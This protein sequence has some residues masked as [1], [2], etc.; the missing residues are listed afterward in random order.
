[1]SG[2]LDAGRSGPELRPELRPDLVVV[3]PW[4]PTPQSPYSGTFV[5]ESVRALMPHTRSVT[6]VHVENQP[7]GQ[8]RRARWEDTP[9]GRLRWIPVP[10]AANTSRGQMMLRQRRALR[11][12]AQRVLS[13]AEVVHCHVGAP[14]AAALTPLLPESARLVVTEHATYL[15][16]VF[17][18]PLARPL[19]RAALRR[20]Q[21]FTA[22]SPSTA[23]LIES[24]FPDT[25]SVQTVP[26]PVELARL[27]VRTTIRPGLPRWLFVGNLIPHKGV[28]RLLRSFAGYLSTGRGDPE[29]TLS[30]AGDG[31][32][33][34][35]L[36]QLAEQLGVA[37][38]V[39]FLGPVAPERVGEVYAGHDLL[40][41]LS[42]VETFGLTCVEAAAAGLAVVVTR[43]GA[44]TDTL[45][46]HRELGLARFVPVN[47][48]HDTGPVV[49]AVLS[50]VDEL[51]DA[52]RVSS[53]LAL[54][55][56]HL[57][58]CYGMRS[59][60]LRLAAAVTGTAAGPL[61]P[62]SGLRGVAV[63]VT[64]EQLLAGQA[65]LADVAD[66]GGTGLLIT[67]APPRRAVPPGV[68]VQVLGDGCFTGPRAQA[69]ARTLLS[70]GPS[71]L[72]AGA[73]AAARVAGARSPRVTL[74]L[75]RRVDRVRRWSTRA[76][77]RVRTG[78]Y[79][80]VVH[81]SRWYRSY[82]EPAEAALTT[83]LDENTTTGAV[84]LVMLADDLLTSRSRGH[85]N[86]H[87]EVQVQTTWTREDV[88][89]VWLTSEGLE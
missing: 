89:R 53:R 46:A 1:M 17:R 9:E 35:E 74:G 67:A 22:V 4:Y 73:D 19:Y 65:W 34:G 2:T 45:V 13:S 55:R 7:P 47:D 51:A 3:T 60:G 69:V 83:L 64:P 54:S 25:P 79:E 23:A 85:L 12:Y 63:A 31:P 62:P 6:V 40:V 77:D 49:A 50:L 76:A 72:L 41:H 56:T 82:R 81:R 28:R 71:R 58:R 48:E 5:R 37:D 70:T 86:G 10:M 15:P 66:F 29:A 20:A 21:A 57:T 88:C 52:P 26:N 75:G 43:C 8:T 87:P 78:P 27:P 14:T 36:E 16:S 80:A 68:L 42:H 32:L 84:T 18:D 61:G 24:S 39:R 33:R 30:V 59:V 44:P 38:R 11:R